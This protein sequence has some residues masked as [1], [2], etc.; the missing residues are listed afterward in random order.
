MPP[1]PRPGWQAQVTSQKCDNTGMRRHNA[2]TLAEL[3]IALLILGV[4]A[5][6]TIPKV[7]QSQQN[8][9]YAAAKETFTMVSEAY[10]A[11]KGSNTVNTNFTLK[12]LTPYMNYVRI[13]T[14]TIDAVSGFNNAS[15]TAP[16]VCLNLHNG[17]SVRFSNERMVGASTSHAINWL[18]D[19]DGVYGGSTIGPS[20]SLECF[21]YFNGRVASRAHI[22]NPTCLDSNCAY[23]PSPFNEPD[24][25]RWW[26]HQ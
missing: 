4:I 6:F 3:L 19:P 9:A 24:W 13:Q 11:Y 12:D 26:G 21:L 14:T 8:S 22:E 20:K 5:T 18:F 23:A 10:Q 7:L 15:C 16:N 1:N 17:G 25:W 2:F